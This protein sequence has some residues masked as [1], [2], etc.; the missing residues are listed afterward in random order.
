M[1]SAKVRHYA[2][3]WDRK[4]FLITSD[5]VCQDCTDIV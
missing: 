4:I 5:A 2:K 1:L 3:M